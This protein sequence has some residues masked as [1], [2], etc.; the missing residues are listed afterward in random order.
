MLN[1]L[2][3]DFRSTFQNQNA[4]YFRVEAE[5]QDDCRNNPP[6]DLNLLYKVN[7]APNIL[8]FELIYED[9]NNSGSSGNYYP[10]DL[11]IAQPPSN[12]SSNPVDLGSSTGG[13]FISTASTNYDSYTLEIYKLS[14]QN[15]P[16]GT[17][18]GQPSPFPAYHRLANPQMYTNPAD[19]PAANIG[20][21][22]KVVVTLSTQGCSTISRSSFFRMPQ[23]LRFGKFGNNGNGN[24]WHNFNP[25]D[26][27]VTVHLDAEATAGE[28]MRLRM[29][30]LD[31]RLLHEDAQWHTGTHTTSGLDLPQGVYL[32]HVSDEQGHTQYREKVSFY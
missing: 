9:P 2:N 28:E 4:T 5:I 18:T 25:E 27:S 1:A 26:Q 21:I 32:L 15:N 17:E 6:V 24:Q 19:N 8:T 11:T 14:N 16:V 23:S 22:Y 30:S 13:L 29:Y 12:N 10:W 20:D 3:Q 31:G 7:A